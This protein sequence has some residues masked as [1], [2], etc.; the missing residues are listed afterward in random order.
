[1]VSNGFLTL[2]SDS[3][4]TARLA[5][6]FSAVSPAIIGDVVVERYIPGKRKY[7]LLTSSVSSSDNFNL[8]V[9]EEDRSIWGNWQNKGNNI[10][11]NT[12]T[13]ITG[14]NAADGFDTQTAN[15]SLYTYDGLTKKYVPF[16][17]T[18]GKNTK[19]T[20]L[21]A[22]VAY[23]MFVYGDRTNS[24]T[25]SLPKNTVLKEKGTLLMGDQIYNTTSANP[26]AD[27]VG[28]YTLLGNP[29]ASPIDW[30]GLEKTNLA[31]TYWGWDPNLNSTGGYITVTTVGN[32]VVISPLTDVAALN[33][34]IQPGQGFFVKTTAPSPSLI[35]KESH[36]VGEN[37]NRAFRTNGSTKLPL[38]AVNLQYNNGIN[39][40][41]ADGAV[42]VFEDLLIN[43]SGAAD[44]AKMV[45]NAE[46]VSIL[47]G[48][49]LLS[50]NGRFMPL[51]NDTLVLHL[52]KLTRPKYNLQIFAKYLPQNVALYL[53]D[54]YLNTT[55]PLST[56]DTNL[57]DFNI[58]AEAASFDPK[59]FQIIFRSASV[60][61]LK[62]VSLLALR[63]HN[64]VLLEWKVASETG[65]SNYVIEHS[66]DGV[67]FFK[68]GETGAY[69]N[70][71]DVTHQWTDNAPA[72]NNCY[73][74]R[75]I[76]SDLKSYYSNVVG[77]KMTEAKSSLKVFP[78]PVE[79]KTMQV[80][81]K[82][83]ETGQYQ[84]D[85][86]N[87]KGGVVYTK[88][89]QHNINSEN[90]LFKLPESIPTGTFLVHI[91]NNSVTLEELI[92]IK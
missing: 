27:V 37:N 82:G 85:V 33:Q 31:N 8:G 78:N 9:G 19:Y 80:S 84:V 61:P 1:M 56:R 81:L 50:I 86:L 59:R 28:R 62:F 17:S 11:A 87:V 83:L 92:L 5:T 71:S 3:A 67:N 30:A 39:N 34:Y 26:L 73:R 79:N 64:H 77:I 44:V 32:S 89:F 24:V 72:T 16:S 36:K 63:K 55:Q 70:S 69:N 47:K 46:C 2:K 43:N 21:K 48:S 49:D 29:Y 58:N 38:L 18:S 66:V 41:F 14:G 42:A 7:R 15:T 52:A 60:L 13:I 23:Y 51:S 75:A 57:V 53:E 10:T 20:P 22:G 90:H 6:V 45:G 40:I 35:I 88:S 12:G 91:R 65:L 25:T 76:Q 4:Y 68:K 74:V 54:H